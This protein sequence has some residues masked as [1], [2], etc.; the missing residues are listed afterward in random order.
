MK[1]IIIL[2]ICCIAALYSCKNNA[3]KDTANAAITRF[4]TEL[5]VEYAQADYCI[6]Y[7]LIVDTDSTN[8]EDILVWGD[9]WVM[10]YNRAGDTLIT[11]SGGSH[12]G[13]MHVKKTEC[14]YEVT[15]FDAVGEGSEFTPTAKAI[16]GDRY[17]ALI[18]LWG[19]EDEKEQ[20]RAKSIL[21]FAAANNLDINYYQDY[22]WPAVKIK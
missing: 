19:K 6:P 2:T 21:D 18:A 3:P 7:S 17:D 16:F 13:C 15:H 5:A 1:R 4:M 22:G 12:P 9:F 8:M 14:D 20:A 11:I 10:N